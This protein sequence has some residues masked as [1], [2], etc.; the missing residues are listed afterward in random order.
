MV[1]VHE[2]FEAGA[3]DGAE[4]WTHG[5]LESAEASEAGLPGLEVGQH[6]TT[7]ESRDE[8]FEFRFGGIMVAP[9]SWLVGKL[10][11]SDG[12]QGAQSLTG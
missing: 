6:L 8:A 4:F 2:F 11:R 7:N 3:L 9:I 10:D 12:A 5:F 1:P